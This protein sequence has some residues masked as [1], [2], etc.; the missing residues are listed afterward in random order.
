VPYL[1]IAGAGHERFILEVIPNPSKKHPKRKVYCYVT[2]DSSQRVADTRT[3]SDKYIGVPKWGLLRRLAAAN[4][5]MFSG[6]REN[7]SLDSYL[8]HQREK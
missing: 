4:N 2:R 8:R 1:G 7:S 3:T 6:K 5:H